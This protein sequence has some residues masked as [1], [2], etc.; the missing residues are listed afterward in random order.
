LTPR[1]DDARTEEKL[2]TAGTKFAEI[3]GAEN[4]RGEE[5]GAGEG[6]EV[7]FERNIGNGSIR[8]PEGKM[9]YRE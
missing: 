5:Y 8:V 2:D 1:R 3:R 6:S 7:V 9:F 4:G